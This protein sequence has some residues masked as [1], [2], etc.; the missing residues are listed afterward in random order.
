MFIVLSIQSLDLD[1]TNKVY[2]VSVSIF[3]RLTT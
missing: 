3:M 2:G 1:H